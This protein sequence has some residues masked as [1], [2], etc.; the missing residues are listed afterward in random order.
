MK[1]VC[2]S[3]T[4]PP[5]VCEPVE[6]ALAGRAAVGDGLLRLLLVVRGAL[7]GAA[8]GIE[9]RG[10][11]V[12]LVLLQ[13]PEAHDRVHTGDREQA[14]HDELLPAHARHGED[15]HDDDG[16]HHHRAEVGLEQ[17]QPDGHAH[18][19][20]DHG[21]APGVDL[22]AVVVAVAGEEHDEAELRQLRRLQREPARQL[23]P[24][25]VALD[26]RAERR[27]HGEQHEARSRRRTTIG[28][29]RRRL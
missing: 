9:E 22:A 24:R 4:K 8:L 18:Q 7:A 13:Q 21:E 27:E 16:E 11:A 14:E 10:E 12:E 20:D 19:P 28:R 5:W 15:G 17:H 26:V 25:L 2:C 23:E 3:G 29:S 6:V 1:S